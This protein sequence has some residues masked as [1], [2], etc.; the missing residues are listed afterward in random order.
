MIV[1]TEA[2]EDHPSH[3]VI[4]PYEDEGEGHSAKGFC[5]S[6]EDNNHVIEAPVPRY[7]HW[8]GEN[9]FCCQGWLMVGADADQAL[10]TLALAAFTWATF[11][12]L[13][14][15]RYDSFDDFKFIVPIIIMGINIV[16]FFKAAL[17]DPGILPRRLQ[18]ETTTTVPGTQGAAA[19]TNRTN[20]GHD[21]A[22]R[23]N[24]DIAQSPCS[25]RTDEDDDEGDS[26]HSSMS[27]CTLNSD[28]DGRQSR[29]DP[30]RLDPYIALY[31]DTNAS[32]LGYCTTCKIIR[33][34]RTRHCRH[35]D[36]CV[37]V[38]D[39]HCP[40]LGRCTHCGTRNQ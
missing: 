40:W 30:N 23:A 25:S 13:P 37:L 1:P 12:C 34:P 10:V 19:R 21:R 18:A 6:P 29:H 7:Y 38:F 11:F 9:W 31:L 4:V 22:T 8:P 15:A 28:V 20:R 36:N 5:D 33:P 35:C 26:R 39:H 16:T 27:V 24:D 32:R 17:M 14:I 2:I 3:A